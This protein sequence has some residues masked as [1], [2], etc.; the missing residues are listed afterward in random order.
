[1]KTIVELEN[2]SCVRC[3]NQMLAALRG[4]DDVQSVSSDFSSGCLV[5]E[6]DGNP[7]AL[8]SLIAATGR[9]VAVA[10]NGERVMVA[11]DG[12]E[13]AECR[14]ANDT[15]GAG[16]NEEREMTAS[17]G[18]TAENG[19]AASDGSSHK[20]RGGVRAVSRPTPGP[21]RRAVRA[22]IRTYRAVF[23]LPRT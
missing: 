20:G 9:A 13:A 18:G 7:Q 11:L 8:V 16:S 22:L 4:R 19:S 15:E 5:V 3:H 1:M 10:A 14:A 23:R 6:H 21:A 2:S 17:R 12:H